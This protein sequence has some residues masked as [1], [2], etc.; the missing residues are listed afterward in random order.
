M[1]Q[2]EGQKCT[3][4][5]GTP[6]RSAKSP[7]SC[8]KSQPKAAECSRVQPCAAVC[9]RVQKR[10]AERAAR[11]RYALCQHASAPLLSLGIEQAIPWPERAAANGLGKS[12]KT[13]IISPRE[14]FLPSRCRTRPFFSAACFFLPCMSFLLLV[15][16][17]LLCMLFLS[18]RRAFSFLLCCMFFVTLAMHFF[19]FCCMF[20]DA[21]ARCTFLLAEC[22][23]MC[24]WMDWVAPPPPAVIGVER[25]RGRGRGR[26]GPRRR[27]RRH[28][29]PPAEDGR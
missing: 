10:A 26:G 17:F 22:M 11:A 24:M 25:G 13:A 6:S 1:R 23:L 9:S 16:F 8:A 2:G 28:R 4:K 20:L 5:R 19:M 14:P 7:A 3:R 15:H 18:A 12:R 29:V 21:R 27:G